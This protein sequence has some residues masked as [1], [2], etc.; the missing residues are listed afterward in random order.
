[1]A[2]SNANNKPWGP[3]V[4]GALHRIALAYP[5]APTDEDKARYGAFVRSLVAVLPCKTCQVGS[6][7]FLED[8]RLDRSLDA[9]GAELFMWTVHFH[10]AIN[11]QL[12]KPIV[13]AEAA[14]ALIRNDSWT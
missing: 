8:G 11:K 7:R 2:S 9:G 14:L 12:R 3:Y 1:M 5:A 6:R 4:W 13:S 10:N